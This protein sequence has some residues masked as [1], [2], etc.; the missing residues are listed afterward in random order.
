FRINDRLVYEEIET[1]PASVHGLL[2]NARFIQ[3]IFDDAADPVRF[4]RFGWDRWDPERH[5]D[6]L[7]AALPDWYRYGLRAF[8]VGLQGG[9]P[10]FTVENSTIDA[11]PFGDD[12]TSIDAAW[13]NR[14][15]RLIRA[16]DELGMV[17]IVSLLYQGQSPR[18]G[19]G[20]VVANAV[21]SASRW[22]G[23]QGYENVI[24][25]VANEHTVGNFQKRPLV[26][27]PES[28]S[29][30]I[31]LAREASGGMPVGASA[32]GVEM[33][34]VVA[35]ASDVIIVHGNGSRRQEYH[36]FLK[37]V[38][39]WEL[40]RP[41]LCN[42]DSPLFSQLDVAFATNTSW[43][44]Y[45]NLTKQEPPAAWGIA[46]AEDLFFARR[47]ARGLGIP[48]EPLPEDE[49]YV[50]D[51]LDDRWQW[52]GRRWVRLT[53]EYPESVNCVEF[54]R[55]GELADVAW[56]EPFYVNYQ[57]TWV[58]DG[59]PTEPGDVWKAVVH[60]GNGEIVERTVTVE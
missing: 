10:V 32:G 37:R 5:T 54:F 56:Q 41:V 8:T 22:L 4:A 15:D 9:M 55:N 60:L 45:N 13:L 17:V 39:A 27:D 36:R 51:G 49:Q 21:R 16:A 46:N 26:H 18:M 3:G 30:L 25:E 1:A 20:T 47:M 42:E 57:E 40:G 28:M 43:G 33:S 7:I 59:V 24:I 44:Y 6:E 23:E 48:I 52:H 2:M 14:L 58:Q 38:R 29:T 50:L 11:N 19:K 34:R 31:E 53:A 12:G 35:E